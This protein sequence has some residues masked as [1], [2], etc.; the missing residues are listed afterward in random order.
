MQERHS[1]RLRYFNELA[2]TS[3]GFYIDYVRQYYS[4]SKG[5]KVLEVG[6]GEEEI[7]CRSQRLI[8]M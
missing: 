1:D 4:I 3:R 8:V 7:Y 6:C 5:C 2:N